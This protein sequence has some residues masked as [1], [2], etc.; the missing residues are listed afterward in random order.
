MDTELNT[1]EIPSGLPAYMTRF[2]GREADLE[3]L[4]RALADPSMRVI[5]LIGPGGVG[6]TR[7]AIEA[8]RRAASKLEGELTFIDGAMLE[9]PGL[10][11]PEMA[12]RLGIDR[13]SGQPV[14][15]QISEALA[16]R[17]LLLVLDN[18]EHLLPAAVNI[19]ALLRALPRMRVLATS[20]SPLHIAG[21]H[22]FAV[23]PLGTHSAGPNSGELSVAGQLFLDRAARVGKPIA[24][25]ANNIAIVETICAYLDGLPLAIEL[26]AARLRMF[27]LAALQSVLTRQLAILTGGPADVSA[28]HRT[29]RAAIDWSYNLLAG[30]ERRLLRELGIFVDSFTLDAARAVCT[31]GDREIDELLESI[32]D[33]ALLVRLEDDIDGQPRF[34][35]LTSI[36]DFAIEQLGKSGDEAVLRARHAA[37][38]LDLAESLVPNLHGEGQHAAVVRLDRMAP[39]VR[40]A[41]SF[42]LAVRDQEAALRMAVA[43]QRYWRIRALWDEGRLAFETAMSLG[44]PEPT[45]L[46]ASALRGAAICA[47]LLFDHDSALDLN[48]RAIAIWE[49]LGDRSGM[50][51]SLIDYGN[52]NNNLG[53]FDEAIAAFEQAATLASDGALRT[54]GVAR[55]SMA[56]AMLRKGALED[57]DRAHREIAPLLRQ[58]DDPSLLAT[59]LSNHAVVRQRLGDVREAQTLLSECLDIQQQLGDEYGIS[60]TLVNLADLQLDPVSTVR[61]A[62]EALEVAL[63]IKALDVS[64]AASVNLGDSALALG[65]TSAAAAHYITALDSYATIGDELGQADVIGLIGALGIESSPVAAA[66]LIGAAQSVYARNDVQATSPQALRVSALQDRLRT[67]LGTEEFERERAVGQE[68][69]LDD[70]VLE[71]LAIARTERARAPAIRVPQPEPTFGNLTPRE[72]DVLRLIADGKTNRQIADALFITLKTAD[73]HVGRILAK[74]ECRNRA[75]AAALAYQHGLISAS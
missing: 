37:W 39:N 46:W 53:R 74:L 56:S 10:L 49:I 68:W 47:E 22:V 26:A 34:R 71:A 69:G 50:A 58:I 27:P 32:Y 72:L 61:Y 21:E 35:M 60:V 15:E 31:P 20:R 64:S 17:S 4:S 38:F 62:T 19:A 66:R 40:Q 8:V 36:R 5:T 44:D 28:R 59:F 55:A 7:L 23:D 3:R 2:F 16:G 73:H 42:L 1:T 6:K 54:S 51:L 52:V 18:M 33:Q 65:D 24:P 41:F 29:L 12:A 25:E 13:S 43:L 75:G 67:L 63:R 30:D 14:G 9:Q 11:L 48:K 70:A 45:P 57:A